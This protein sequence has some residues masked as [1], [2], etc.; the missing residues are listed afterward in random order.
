MPRDT[1]YQP[2]YENDWALI[3]GIDAYQHAP[4]LGYA[5]SDANAI[6]NILET[7]FKF[8]NSNIT[9][10]KDADATRD[11]INNAFFEFT[12][13]KI[14]PDDRLLVFFAGHGHTV[15][16]SRGEVGFLVPV[17]GSPENLAT[18]I[19]WDALTRN[20]ELIAAKHIL[21]I[22]DACYGGLA[23]TRFIPPG[24]MRFAKDMLQRFTRQ[25]LTAGKADEVV[26]DSGGP[27]AGHSIFTGHLLDALEG[28]ASMQEGI[29]TASEVMSY[30][31]NRVATDYNSQ[32][33]P[34]YSFLDGDG[35]F[36]FD[37]SALQQLSEK[38]EIDKDVL[39]EI[40][41]SAA[42][43]A[44]P[45]EPQSIVDLTKEYL[46][47]SKYRIK[48][49]DL[50][51]GEVRRLLYLT[52]E[53]KFPVQ[54]ATVTNAEFSERL[55]QYESVVT[56]LQKIV[57]LI[58][59]WGTEEHMSILERI[60]SRLGDTDTLSGGKVIWLGLRWYPTML[61]MYAGGI[62]ALSS[63]NYKNLS[64]IFI[65]KAGTRHSGDSTK[66]VIIPTVEG[67]L[68]VQRSDMF[69]I[70]P[71]HD[72]HYAPRSEY[73]F[74]VL[75]PIIEDILFLGK[76]YEQAYDIF[77][78]YHAL[79]YADLTYDSRSQSWGPPGRFAWKYSSSEGDRNPF[80]EITSEARQH[81]DN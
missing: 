18:L 41:P 2:Y 19:R 60:F 38:P 8:T 64:K 15:S 69:K 35:D 58:A 22:M 23:A 72:R 43:P 36:I 17:D 81:G 55:K 80:S 52:G 7:Q 50:V 54:T 62:A 1:I 74:K 3:I 10:L 11:N 77:E 49:D 27:R 24:S 46:S 70:L 6:A 12:K 42:T 47:D 53:D 5:C 59:K 26:A 16:G 76:S 20:A 40:P 31:Y 33:T 73:L 51:S 75:Q 28:S 66:E 48:L 78:I 39:I 13:D 29:L 21:F 32:Q 25:V 65:T 9:V 67:L 45:E 56:D 44:M 57:I 34:H 79:V 14:G 71:G 68:D 61:L 37:T 63:R 30:V 4:P